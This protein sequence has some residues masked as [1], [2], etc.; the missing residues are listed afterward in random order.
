MKKN[1]ARIVIHQQVIAKSPLTLALSCGMESLCGLEQKHTHTHKPNTICSRS[2]CLTWQGFSLP[3]ELNNSELHLSE[4]SVEFEE[5]IVTRDG[6]QIKC[7]RCLKEERNLRLLISRISKFL[8]NY[9]P[10]QLRLIRTDH[11]SLFKSPAFPLP[12]LPSRRLPVP[13][14]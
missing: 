6:S 2:R 14:F 7:R 3:A 1:P 5:R 4:S 8:R 9:Y 13:H 11:S 12:L 10:G